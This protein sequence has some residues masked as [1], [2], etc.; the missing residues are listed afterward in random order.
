MAIRDLKARI[1]RLPMQPGVYLFLGTEGEALYV[2]KARV[3]RDRVRSFVEQEIIPYERDA[4][5]TS[6]GPTD[7]LRIELNA[8]ARRAGL[9]APHVSAHVLDR[10]D[11]LGDARSLGAG[12]G[13]RAHGSH[14]AR[15]QRAGT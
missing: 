15:S 12:A 2:G 7:E 1:D 11:R 5:L 14:S 8:L 10:R 9:L 3:L 6:H 13:P 4:R